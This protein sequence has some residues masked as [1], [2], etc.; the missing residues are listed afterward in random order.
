MMATNGIDKM[1]FTFTG[2]MGC[3]N[4]GG[5]TCHGGKG[6]YNRSGQGGPK[7]AFMG[8]MAYNRTWWGHD[9]YALTIG[10]GQMNNPGRYLTLL[11]PING[12][13]AVSGS[14]YFPAIP[15]ARPS[16]DGTPTS[17]VDAEVVHS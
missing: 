12:A 3:E 16:Y 9:K 2:D 10:G 15:G 13:D 11:P 4:G 8:W 17:P 5:V 14:P 1:A 6:A 7:Q